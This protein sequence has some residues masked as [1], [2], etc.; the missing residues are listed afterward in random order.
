M[1]IFGRSSLEDVVPGME[2]GRSERSGEDQ[3][4]CLA[5]LSLRCRVDHNVEMPG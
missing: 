3:E 2:M 1:R 5:M 4:F